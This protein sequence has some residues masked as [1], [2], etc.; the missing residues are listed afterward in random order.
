MHYTGIA[1]EVFLGRY[2][3]VAPGWYGT[4]IAGRRGRITAGKRDPREPG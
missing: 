1:A 3:G 2:G 4:C